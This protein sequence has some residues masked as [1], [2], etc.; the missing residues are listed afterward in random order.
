MHARTYSTHVLYCA[1]EHQPLPLLCEDPVKSVL[2]FMVRPHV[3]PFPDERAQPAFQEQASRRW[4]CSVA[5]SWSLPGW[6]FDFS[7]LPLGREGSR[8]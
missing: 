8:S 4:N 2:C 3:L 1:V 5:E 6:E 7:I